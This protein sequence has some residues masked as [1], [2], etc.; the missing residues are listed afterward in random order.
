MRI[1][2]IIWVDSMTDNGWQASDYKR[3]PNIKCETIGFL[4]AEDAE[5]VTLTS[6]LS[7][8]NQPRSPITIPKAAIVKRTN[9]T[10]RKTANAKTSSRRLKR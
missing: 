5:T 2:R 4:F 1:Q 8:F 6:C 7:S 9:V 10:K 3:V